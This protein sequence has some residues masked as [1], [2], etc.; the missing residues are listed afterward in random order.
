M[1]FA[2]AHEISKTATTSHAPVIATSPVEAPANPS[3]TGTFLSASDKGRHS[4]WNLIISIGVGILFIA[5]VSML[6]SY[7]NSL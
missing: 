3:P 7:R 4:N 5:I 6:I 2:R 1:N